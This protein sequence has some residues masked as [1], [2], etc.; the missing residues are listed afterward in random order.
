VRM[1]AEL[2]GGAGNSNKSGVV[3]TPQ[4]Q[5]SISAASGRTPHCEWSADSR[6]CTLA[7]WEQAGDAGAY[8][9]RDE[10]LTM[11]MQVNAGLHCVAR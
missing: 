9:I 10:T 2:A 1:T 6:W 8:R 5:T 11:T 3:R 4:S 7:G